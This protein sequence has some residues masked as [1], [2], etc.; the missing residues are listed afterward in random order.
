MLALFTKNITNTKKKWLRA[1][2]LS[3]ALL[4][5]VSQGAL[6]GWDDFYSGI[7]QI[8]NGIQKVTSSSVSAGFKVVESATKGFWNGLHSDIA[9]PQAAQDL[10]SRI[11]H[12]QTLSAIHQNTT[13]LA[14]SFKR[15]GHHA[16]TP[17]RG[18]YNFWASDNKVADYLRTKPEENRYLPKVMRSAGDMLKGCVTEFGNIAYYSAKNIAS[19]WWHFA[20]EYSKTD[21]AKGIR[22]ITKGSRTILTASSEPAIQLAKDH[23]YLAT[24]ILGAM[25]AGIAYSTFY[26]AP[27]MFKFLQDGTNIGMNFLSSQVEDLGSTWANAGNIYQASS[28][29]AP[30]LALQKDGVKAFFK[31]LGSSA[32]TPKAWWD[33]ISV[34]RSHLLTRDALSFTQFSLSGV[35][36]KLGALWNKR[37]SWSDAGGTAL[38][39]AASGVVA[40]NVI[41]YALSYVLP[42]GVSE[43]VAATYKWSSIA[44]NVLVHTDTIYGFRKYPGIAVQAVKT[45]L[46]APFGYGR[47][48]LN[49]WYQNVKGLFYKQN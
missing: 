2:A 13:D 49:G 32:F 46:E 38:K 18:I 9:N 25:T 19:P 43:A 5:G 23:P 42:P 30:F 10:P 16:T 8:T 37:I 36:A 14:L 31:G 27:L 26:T 29:M 44:G 41:R 7:N 48:K 47:D 35:G 3:A 17:L 21:Y 28:W 34:A 24:G 12:S 22:K 40:Q 45:K 33:Q 20:N 11:T 6:A 15:F 39:D 1:S 4:G